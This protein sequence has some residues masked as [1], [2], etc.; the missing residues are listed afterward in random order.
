[1]AWHVKEHHITSCQSCSIMPMV[2]HSQLTNT[3]VASTHTRA[4]THAQCFIYNG[5]PH[6]IG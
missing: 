6:A 2:L 1:M 5:S 4:H 3:E